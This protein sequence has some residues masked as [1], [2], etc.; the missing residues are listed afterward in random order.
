MNRI[1][2]APAVA[3]ASKSYF[4][5]TGEQWLLEYFKY[6]FYFQVLSLSYGVSWSYEEE[7]LKEQQVDLLTYEY[8]CV[9]VVVS[10]VGIKFYKEYWFIHGI[11]WM[12]VSYR[13]IIG[14]EEEG[15]NL[16]KF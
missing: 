4:M 14:S 10:I 12:M 5:P 11:L 13:G 2:G 6:L 16:R 3:A 1:A 7:F 15:Y 8:I 9:V